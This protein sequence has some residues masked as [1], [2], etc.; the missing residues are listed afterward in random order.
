[1]DVLGSGHHLVKRVRDVVAVAVEGGCDF[2]IVQ[3]C[4]P[5]TLVRPSSRVAVTV[6]RSGQTSITM[7]TGGEGNALTATPAF[8]RERSN[9]L[10]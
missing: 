3:G 4:F 2:S 6:V 8:N 5:H 10:H 9:S 7:E 1:M